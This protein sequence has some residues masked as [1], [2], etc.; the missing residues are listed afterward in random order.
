MNFK[1]YY[2]S[3]VGLL[4]VISDGEG[5][6]K[7]SLVYEEESAVSNAQTEEA[8]RQLQQYFAGKRTEFDLPL[9]ITGTPFQKRVYNALLKVPYGSTVSY[10]DL[11][12]MAGNNRGFQATGQAVHHNQHMIVIP[13]H[14]VISNDGSIGGYT[15]DI[16]I[17]KQLLKLEGGWKID[18]N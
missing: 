2:K 8:V 12:I 11:T 1:S 7:V 15:P 4:Q 14:R 16:N 18:Y 9:K 6:T 13:C 3:P 17:K 10:K 5:I